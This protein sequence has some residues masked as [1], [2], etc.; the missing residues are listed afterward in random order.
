M[1]CLNN[2]SFVS[3]QKLKDDYNTV[4][5]TDT[6]PPAFTNGTD[7]QSKSPKHDSD[8]DSRTEAISLDSDSTDNSRLT[9]KKKTDTHSKTSKRDDNP[10]TYICRHCKYSNVQWFDF[11]SHCKVM[12]NVVALFP[13]TNPDCYIFYISKNG[14]KGHCTRLHKKELTCAE[15]KVMATSLQN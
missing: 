3:V 15:C 8:S 7:R 10:V 9:T 1:S 12:H 2:I 11:E 6:F 14:L 5:W 4:L 13:C